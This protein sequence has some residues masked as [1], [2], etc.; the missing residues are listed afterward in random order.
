[1]SGVRKFRVRTKLATEVMKGGGITVSDAL[2]R[3]DEGLEPLRDVCLR[4]VDQNLAEID[5][6]FG[7]TAKARAGEDFEDLYELSSRVI[8]SA[9]GLPD[10][11]IDSAARA[12][13]D[14]A[15]LSLEKDVRDWEAIDVH[16]ET[17]KLLRQR[18]QSFTQAQRDSVLDGLKK[19]TLKRVGDPNAIS[20]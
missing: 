16:I 8:D 18:G 14:L 7:M 20:G 5:K 9:L 15:D 3:A 6:R 1:M 17:L 4:I 19:V 11:G 12:L 13:C 10:S 2:K